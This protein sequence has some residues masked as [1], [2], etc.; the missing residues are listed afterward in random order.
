MFFYNYQEK[1]NVTHTKCA[2]KADVRDIS[3]QLVLYYIYFCVH[4]FIQK[5]FVGYHTKVV[6][7]NWRNHV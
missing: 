3:L 4:L 1:P 7:F 2:T 6:N 5:Q